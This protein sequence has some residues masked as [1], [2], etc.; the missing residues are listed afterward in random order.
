MPGL[1]FVETISFH[2]GITLASIFVLRSLDRIAKWRK[3]ANM[4][5]SIRQQLRFVMTR[6]F[7]QAAMISLFLLFLFFGGFFYGLDTH[8]YLCVCST[9]HSSSSCS[10][11]FYP[12]GD[13]KFPETRLFLPHTYTKCHW[14]VRS[15]IFWTITSSIGRGLSATYWGE[16]LPGLD[17][18]VRSRHCIED[19]IKD[20]F[21]LIPRF[22]KI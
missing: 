7:L 17:Y 11:L 6:I 20:E 8:T 14:K 1:N 4:P 10:S 5:S 9:L 2:G 18:V 22:W 16:C 12:S 3:R 13:R 15:G 19:F 21:L